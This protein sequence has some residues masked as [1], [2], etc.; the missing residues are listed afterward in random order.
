LRTERDSFKSKL[1]AI[2]NKIYKL[3]SNQRWV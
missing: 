1:K 3:K 2:E